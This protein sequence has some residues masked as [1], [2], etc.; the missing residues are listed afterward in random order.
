MLDEMA[1]PLLL[2][3]VKGERAILAE[4]IR[5]VGAGEVPISALGEGGA[6]RSDE[7]P[8]GM[9][10]WGKLWYDAQLAV[11]LER[12][13]KAVAIARH[14]IDEQPA[15]WRAW[16]AENATMQRNPIDRYMGLLPLLLTPAVASASQAFWRYQTDLAANAILLAAERHRKKTG[17]WPESV[18]A[19]E[20][21]ILPVAPVD[22]FSGGSFQMEHR[23]GQFLVFSIGPNGENEHGDYDPKLWM[24]GGPDD[25]GAGAWDVS[26]RREPPAVEEE[27]TD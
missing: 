15:L 26:L 9:S 2:T 7:A 1:Q 5:R 18:A 17:K 10:P 13:T 25:A 16:E 14:P 4:I 19:I 24:R 23:D 21:G 20:R 6:R 27:Q 8:A 11:A 12:M 3:G 22:P